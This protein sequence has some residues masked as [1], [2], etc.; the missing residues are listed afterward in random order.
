MATLSVSWD[1]HSDARLVWSRCDVPPVR[2]SCT[3]FLNTPADAQDFWETAVAAT[4]RLS[5]WNN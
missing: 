5:S 2:R 4:S 1:V 3:V